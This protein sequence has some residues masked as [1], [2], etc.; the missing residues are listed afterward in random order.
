MNAQQQFENVYAKEVDG[1]WRFCLWKVSDGDTALDIT[2]ECFMRYWDELAGGAE[3]TNARAF[4]FT[5]A[6]R[7]V[8][9]WYRK[10]RAV[11]LESMTVQEGDPFDP[12]DE[13]TL[14]ALG[15]GGEARYA[16]AMLDR[17]DPTYRQAV[18][19]RY[20]EGLGPK[21]IAEILNITADAASVRI[22]RGMR[23]L[24]ALLDP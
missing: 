17:L 6:R 8:I 3:I 12:P 4:L 10:K 20:V 1:I 22:H 9:D 23:E 2:Q 5:V 18:Y 14:D 7:L 19:L 16:V 15:V 21:E 11:S 13:R 24:R